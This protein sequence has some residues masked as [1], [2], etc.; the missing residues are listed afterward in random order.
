MGGI[1]GTEEALGADEE[2]GIVVAPQQPAPLLESSEDAGHRV[3][4]RLDDEE[5]PAHVGRAPLIGE[6][7]GL[8]GGQ[9]ISPALGVVLAV[10]AGR[11]VEQPLANVALL[12]VGLPGQLGGGHGSGAGHRL[13]EPEPLA[14]VDEIGGERRAEVAH[15]LAQELVQLVFIDRSRRGHENL[16]RSC[17]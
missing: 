13:I 12:G 9:G 14:D 15:D 2:V 17:G 3:S 16:P 7:Q 10:A 11:L 6:G 5:A 8:L 1:P 4:H